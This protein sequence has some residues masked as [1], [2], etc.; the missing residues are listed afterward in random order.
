MPKEG[1]LDRKDGGCFEGGWYPNAH[2]DKIKQVKLNFVYLFIY[3]LCFKNLSVVFIY[4]TSKLI[5]KS[6]CVGNACVGVSF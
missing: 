4:F 2:Y 3:L 5:T 1:G 6:Y